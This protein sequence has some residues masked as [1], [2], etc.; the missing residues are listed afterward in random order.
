MIIFPKSY[1]FFQTRFYLLR[2]C[3]PYVFVIL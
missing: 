2:F 1:L 3:L